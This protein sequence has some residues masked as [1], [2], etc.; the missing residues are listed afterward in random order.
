MSKP[1]IALKRIRKS[2]KGLAKVYRVKDPEVW[3]RPIPST[4]IISK[5]SVRK[6]RGIEII[7]GELAEKEPKG[8][9]GQTED[10]LDVRFLDEF[11]REGLFKKLWVDNSISTAPSCKVLPHGSKNHI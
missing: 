7:L 3:R 8:K 2:P 1:S 9:T 11:E 5:A 6:K 4:S 10:F